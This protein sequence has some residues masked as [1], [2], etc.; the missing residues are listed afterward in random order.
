MS[1]LAKVFC[2]TPNEYNLIFTDELCCNEEIIPNTSI[3]GELCCHEETILNN[4]NIAYN[5]VAYMFLSR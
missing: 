4:S 1:L 3:S 5:G 2:N